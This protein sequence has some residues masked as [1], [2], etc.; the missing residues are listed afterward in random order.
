MERMRR[1]AMVMV[2]ILTTRTLMTSVG[3]LVRNCWGRIDSSVD[4]LPASW[5]GS[6]NEIVA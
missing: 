2:L 5:A 6:S 4:F 1:V 3:M